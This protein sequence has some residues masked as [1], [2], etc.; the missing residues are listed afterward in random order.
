MRVH[1]FIKLGLAAALFAL[2]AQ[3]A[4]SQGQNEPV[5]VQGLRG[6]VEGTVP[7]HSDEVTEMAE[8]HPMDLAHTKS[9]SKPK[10]TALEA[11]LRRG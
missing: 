1:T 4:Q 7:G 11:A 3:M 8:F 10:N 2:G 9:M 5:K 6:A